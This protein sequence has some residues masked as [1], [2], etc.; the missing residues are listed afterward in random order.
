MLSK[1]FLI[2]AVLVAVYLVFSIPF[3]SATQVRIWHP[4]AQLETAIPEFVSRE[5]GARQVGTNWYIFLN[6]SNKTENVFLEKAYLWACQNL[7]PAQCVQSKQPFSYNITDN[8]V[9]IN[10]SWADIADKL[11]G[12]PQTGNLLFFV[13]TGSAYGPNWHGWWYQINRTAASTFNFYSYDSDTIDLYASSGL[14]QPYPIK[15]FIEQRGMLPVNPAWTERIVIGGIN[16]LF[17]LSTNAVPSFQTDVV[18]GNQVNGIINNWSFIFGSNTVIKN[19]IT[20]NLNPVARCGNGACESTLGESWSSCCYDCAC[21]TGQYCDAAGFCKPKPQLSL[22]GTPDTR[23]SNCYVSHILNINVKLENAPSDLNIISQKYKLGPNTNDVQCVTKPGRIYTCPITVPADPNCG[24]GEFRLSGNSITF[25]I[26]YTDGARGEKTESLSTSFPDVVVG[27]WS[28]GQNGCEAQ[29]GETSENCCYDCGCPSGYFCDVADSPGTGICKENI[30][31]DNLQITASPSNFL[32]P[33]PIQTYSNT[34]KLDVQLFNNPASLTLTGASCSIACIKPEGCRAS[35]SIVCPL[36]SYPNGNWSCQL[37]FEI[38]S[39]DNTKDFILLPTINFDIQYNNG[40]NKVE[41]VLSKQFGYITIASAFCGDGV[42]GE[43]ENSENCCWDCGCSEGNFC[44]TAGTTA[45]PND[46]CKSLEDIGINIVSPTQPVQLTGF[47]GVQSAED[48]NRFDP[49][50]VS[51]KVEI[52][53]MPAGIAEVKKSCDFAGDPTFCKIDCLKLETKDSKTTY[54]CNITLPEFDSTS[55]FYNAEK[56]AIELTNNHIVFDLKFRDG[57]N[58]IEKQIVGNLP[59]IEIAAKS[60][61]GVGK[62]YTIPGAKCESDIGENSDNCCIDCGCGEGYICVPGGTYKESTCTDKSQ[63]TATIE[64]VYQIK[65]EELGGE[66]IQTETSVECALLAPYQKTGPKTNIDCEFGYSTGAP[67]PVWANISI[68]NA[69]ADLMIIPF[70]SSFELENNKGGISNA[71]LVEERQG[72]VKVFNISFFPKSLSGVGTSVGEITKTLKLSLTAYYQGG[73]QLEFTPQKS[74]SI[75]LV[76]GPAL[77]SC[78]DKKDEIDDKWHTW[79]KWKNG[80]WIATGVL[81]LTAGALAFAST[82]GCGLCGYLAW[83][84]GGFATCAGG[85]A[86]DFEL[87]RPVMDNLRDAKHN[88]C[89]NPDLADMYIKRAQNRQSERDLWTKIGTSIICAIGGFMIAYCIVKVAGGGEITKVNTMTAISR[90]TPKFTLMPELYATVQIHT[91]MWTTTYT[92]WWATATYTT[93][94]AAGLMLP[95]VAKPPGAPA[96]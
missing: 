51:V 20:L 50:K 16:K 27:S 21:L 91:I 2:C 62:G 49:H 90:T 25:D 61:C 65:T 44:D 80:L 75:K 63:I 84:A 7:N 78:Q 59:D 73:Q 87:M 47:Y 57:L 60:Y 77:K 10:V 15:D 76:E 22:Y 28:C 64:N 35:C 94:I 69:P 29:L 40:P 85:Y 18:E 66:S 30:T 42:C 48:P 93:L 14:E 12:Y 86:I 43:D 33:G 72:N 17:N 89:T 53:N 6:L 9:S 58:M 39:Y 67:G 36:Q 52:N 34:T 5:I 83:C 79:E 74:I 92:A 45:T 1:I 38:P 3:V 23:V 82:L 54:E 37:D 46:K 13:R 4:V 70:L 8:F 56:K 68:S 24:Q 96:S 32:P 88:I 95:W 81:T 31:T 41:Q 26:S 55:T 19:P 11:I 71:F